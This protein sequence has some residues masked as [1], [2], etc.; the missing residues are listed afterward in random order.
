[1]MRDGAHVFINEI[2]R[3]PGALEDA[4]LAMLQFPWNCVSADSSIQN[5]L[6]Q[7]ASDTQ[8]VSVVSSSTTKLRCIVEML[9][10]H[11]RRC[12]SLRQEH[13]RAGIMLKTLLEM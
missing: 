12:C 2:Q 10:A 3:S 11:T 13:A 8:T 1:M 7:K 4:T 5:V 9:L 6:K